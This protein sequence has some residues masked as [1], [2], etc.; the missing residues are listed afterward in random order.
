MKICQLSHCNETLS[1]YANALQELVEQII[2]LSGNYV[3]ITCLGAK[4]KGCTYCSLIRDLKLHD[5]NATTTARITI[6]LKSL[7]KRYE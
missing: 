2:D 7:K 4:L 5:G 3:T 6:K 1:K